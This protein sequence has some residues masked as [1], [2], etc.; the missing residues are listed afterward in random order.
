MGDPAETPTGPVDLERA[1]LDPA[2]VFSTPEAVLLRADLSP[3]AKADVLRWW[4]YD[5]NEVAV[6]EEEGMLGED[7]DLQRRVL[8]ALLRLTGHLQQTAPIKQHGIA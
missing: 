5:A 3:A 8:L 1:L 6:A 4:A 2:A 7:T